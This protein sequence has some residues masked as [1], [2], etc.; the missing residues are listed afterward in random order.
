MKAY[1]ITYVTEDAD[2]SINFPTEISLL[3]EST[4]INGNESA[5]VTSIVLIP[6]DQKLDAKDI[7]VKLAGKMDVFSDSLLVVEVNPLNLGEK[8]CPALAMA[9]LKQEIDMGKNEVRNFNRFHSRH[10]GVIQYQKEKPQWAYESGVLANLPIPFEEWCW[11]PV[12]GDGIYEKN[13]YEKYI[14]G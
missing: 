3:G 8:N 1:L 4:K 14:R 5:S 12:K 10:E 11:L 7:R 9:L 13:K 6:R 2:R